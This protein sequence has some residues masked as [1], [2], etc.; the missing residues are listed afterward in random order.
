MRVVLISLILSMFLIGCTT[1]NYNDIPNN[2]INEKKLL[3]KTEY[4]EQ[5]LLHKYFARY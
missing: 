5:A 2:G 1:L 4:F 3:Q